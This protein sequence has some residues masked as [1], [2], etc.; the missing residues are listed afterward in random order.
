MNNLS[1]DIIICQTFFQQDLYP[2]T[3]A[4]YKH[5]QTSLLYSELS[6]MQLANHC[7]IAFNKETLL[8]LHPLDN[9]NCVHQS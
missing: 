3:F 2:S 4:K 9:F 8:L 5:H 1:T 7:D 6:L